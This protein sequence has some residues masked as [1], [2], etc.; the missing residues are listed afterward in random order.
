MSLDHTFQVPTVNV[1]TDMFLRVT[2]SVVRVNGMPKMRQ[3]YV[4]QPVMGKTPAELRAYIDGNDPTTGRPVMQEIVEGLTAP[5]DP[6]GAAGV[7]FG[8]TTPRLVEPDTE[9][10]LNQL[11]LD[12]NWTD[13]LP[14]ILPTEARVAE[15]LRHTSHPPD[16]VVGHMRPTGFR[17]FWE[18]TVEKVA[19]NAVMAG[20]RPEY[21]PVV[22]ALAAT[23]ASARGSTTSSAAAMAVVNGP[24]RAEIGMNSGTGALGPYNH[25]NATIGRAWGLL[26]QNLQGGSEPGLTYLGSQGNNYA[27]N[28]I[29]FAENEERSP[30]VPFHVQQGFAP[31]VSTVSAFGGCRSTAFTLG[32]REK[33]WREH[34]RSMLRGMDPHESPVLVLDPITARQFIDRGGFDTKEKLI[35]WVY[36]NAQMPAGEYWDYQLIQNYIYPRATFGEEPYASKLKAKEDELIPM[37]RREQIQVVVV[38]GETNGYWRIFGAGY[39]KTVSVDDWR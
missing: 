3:V 34:V 24:V 26:S 15:M 22:L 30:W 38:G 27:Y 13:K 29:C 37:F 5:L 19:V 32:L 16:E 10:N 8:R 14:I 6:E 9:E 23:G 2:R 7:G 35:D 11:F 33:H 28:S 21:F 1:H 39:N 25:A 17:E 31:G 36:E 18:Y 20:C 4:P 12:R